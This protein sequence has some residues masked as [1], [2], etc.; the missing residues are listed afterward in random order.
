[1][2]NPRDLTYDELKDL[3]YSNLS[4]EEIEDFK[5]YAKNCY[6][7][8][9]SI[10][11][12]INSIYG[13]FGN[14]HFHFYNSD[15]A[16]TIT[17]QG[18][19]AIKYTEMMIE[20]YFKEFFHKDKDLHKKLGVPDGVDVPKIKGSIYKYGDTDS[21]YL[22]FEEVLEA[23]KWKG[24][25]KDFVLALNEFRL[26]GF[27]KKILADF[28][29]ARNSDNYLD[30][31]LE[32]I[33]ES[34]IFVAKKKY[35]QNIVW[36]DGKHFDPLT[37]IKTTGLEIVQ[38]STP[39]FARQKLIEVIKLIFSKKSLKYED[40]AD[41]I[42]VLKQIKEEFKITNIEKLSVSFGISDYNKYIIN[43][44]DKLEIAPKCP[45]HVRAAGNFNHLVNKNK[46][47]TKYE[48]IHSGDKIKFYYTTDVSCDVFGFKP[49]DFPIEIAPKM[50][51][52]KQFE[53]TIIN[54]LNRV[55]VAAGL[56]ALNPV[57][58]YYKNTLF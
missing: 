51:I 52:D 12:A 37:Y 32:T 8:E 55:I 13:A 26:A 3:D 42:K 48:L 15:I 20:K 17:L 49:G 21:G 22:S 44:V 19:E 46:L 11:L 58:S 38:S 9:Q 34:G 53:N 50:D 56:P 10:K 25:E 14:N 47:K 40:N 57:L 39:P 27:I 29:V 24:T 4:S 31:E 18:Q 7:Q 33:A 30:F 54:P 28:A 35:V 43:D 45:I 23:V 36:K 2:I 5:S 16:E 6:S 41:I 1:M